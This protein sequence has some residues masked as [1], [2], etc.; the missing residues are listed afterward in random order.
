MQLRF[1]KAPEGPLQLGVELDEYVP[2]MGPTKA[3][4][5]AVVSAFKY[6]VGDDLYHSVGD[7][8]TCTKGELERPIFSMPLWC[9]DQFIETPEGETPPDMTDPNFGTWGL[10]RAGDYKAYEQ[11]LRSTKFRPG[12]TYTFNFYSISPFLDNV[13][14]KIGG[15]IPGVTIDMNQFCGR[16]PI[17]LVLYSLKPP[18]KGS[19]HDQRHV[20]SRKD[21]CFHMVFWST[22]RPPPSERVRQLLPHSYAA[23]AEEEACI[24]TRG[25]KASLRSGSSKRPAFFTCFE[26]CIPRRGA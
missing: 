22:L 18:P 24:A 3:A 4:M 26:G 12:P 15:I 25:Q 19:E 17:H 20:D 14:W 1:K 8:P 9:I 16:P 21:Y 13:M 5:K 6:V 10:Q 2:L 23:E 11:T 7:D